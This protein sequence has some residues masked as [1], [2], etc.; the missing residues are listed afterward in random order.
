MS[1]EYEE[2]EEE[3]EPERIVKRKNIES[4]PMDEDEAL[5]QMDLLNHDFFAFKNTDEECVSVIYVRKD[6]SYGILNIK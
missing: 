2:L 1:F 6:G 3:E 4:K 5:L